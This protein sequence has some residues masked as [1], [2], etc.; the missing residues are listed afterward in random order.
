MIYI[1]VLPRLAQSK[2]SD[3]FKHGKQKV[4]ILS[5]RRLLIDYNLCQN[6]SILFVLHP[7]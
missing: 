2:L 3:L 1:E 6:K 7:I 5:S 4:K